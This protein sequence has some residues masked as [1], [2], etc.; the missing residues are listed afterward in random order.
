MI[1][2]C[3]EEG[4]APDI[5]L[6]PPSDAGGIKA[7]EAVI[8]GL[9]ARDVDPAN[10]AIV[11]FVGKERSRVITSDAIGGIAL[12]K[13][14]GRFD[15]AGNPV[16]TDGRMLA[17]T[18]YR[19]KGQA[20]PYVV[21]CEVDFAVLD[22]QQRRKLFVGMTRAQ[23]HLTLVMSHAAEAAIMESLSAA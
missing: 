17:E 10:I 3:P 13:F 1:A 20:A 9:L 12:R 18:L 8:A 14:A 15:L 7:L 23:L 4:E 6:Y 5:R 19:F 21:L 11:T 2:R 22:E 16:W